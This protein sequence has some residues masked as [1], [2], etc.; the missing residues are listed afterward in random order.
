MTLTKEQLQVL[1]H[2]VGADQYGRG[3]DNRNFFGTDKAGR[4]G[5]ICESLVAMGLMRSR[6]PVELCHGEHV[7]HV[8]D[9][10]VQRFVEADS[11]CNF[12]EWLGIKNRRKVTT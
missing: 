9:A 12:R 2:S 4:D 11:G 10:G 8:T 5:Q 6:G 1:Q 3:G 7:Y